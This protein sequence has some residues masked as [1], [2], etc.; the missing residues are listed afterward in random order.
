MKDQSRRGRLTIRNPI[1]DPQQVGLWNS[2]V[3]SVGAGQRL[4]QQLPSPAAVVIAGTAKTAPTTADIAVDDHPLSSRPTAHAPSE[5]SYFAG[6]VC[7]QDMGK[8][9]PDSRPPLPHPQIDPI[10]RSRSKPHQDHSGP[11][12]RLHRVGVVED[13]D[14][15]M[16]GDDHSFHYGETGFT[17][18]A[19]RQNLGLVAL[20]T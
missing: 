8:L 5:C 20:G 2:H 3:L 10:E 16:C 15:A 4:A 6:P 17:R 1:G 12:F 14:A 11:G 13:I 7:P 9:K 19:N 18:R